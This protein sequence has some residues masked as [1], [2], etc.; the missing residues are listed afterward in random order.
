MLWGNAGYLVPTLQIDPP[1]AMHGTWI[2]CQSTATVGSAS[3]V[4]SFG[5]AQYKQ[6][7]SDCS[8]SHA[9]R[10]LRNPDDGRYWTW[11]CRIS[12]KPRLRLCSPTL[13]VRKEAR[14]GHGLGPACPADLDCHMYRSVE[15]MPASYITPSASRVRWLEHIAP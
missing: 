6:D 2:R 5:H 8:G 3:C 9:C 13:A 10:P 12:C 11:L 14:A 7:R 15:T 4:N 1:S